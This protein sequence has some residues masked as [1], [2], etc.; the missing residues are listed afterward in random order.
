MTY[1]IFSFKSENNYFL[2]FILFSQNFK[3]EENNINNNSFPSIET[4][5]S[6]FQKFI[7]LD[8]YIKNSIL[9]F[10][11]QQKLKLCF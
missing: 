7:F 8:K 5:K 3:N 1:S 4:L 10:A 9:Q 11:F 6:N 2:N